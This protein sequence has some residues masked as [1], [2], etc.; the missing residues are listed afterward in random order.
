[1]TAKQGIIIAAFVA[2]LAALGGSVWYFF[3][4]DTDSA[5]AA[6]SAQAPATPTAPVAHGPLPSPVVV[7][8]DKAALL[9]GSKAGQDITNQIRAF[10]EQAKAQLD[11][12][13]RAL[14]ADAAS[15]KSR[16]GGMTPEQRQ[17]AVTAFEGRQAAFQ[18]A[19]NLQQ[20][21]IQMAL[22]N[23]NHE[24]EKAVGPI[25]KQVM[26]AHHANIVFDKQVVIL[27]TD[28]NFDITPEVVQKLDGVLSSVK[29][30][31]P[32]ESAVPQQAGGATP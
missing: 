14:Q 10:A 5:P 6:D 8:I 27:S 20:G 32:P 3:L 21:R 25:L 16:A 18:R 2:V 15:L 31:L 30:E 17:A 24:M 7:V 13:G 11:P 1:M 19:A 9:R 4:R 29:V 12:Q 23:A 28:N 26:A 22:A